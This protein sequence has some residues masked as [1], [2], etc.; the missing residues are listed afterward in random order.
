M[1]VGDT[2]TAAGTRITATGAAPVLALCRKLVERGFDPAT[3]LEAY[4]GRHV[5][6]RVSSLAAGAGLDVTTNRTGRPV[7]V[8][9]AKASGS[10]SGWPN[11]HVLMVD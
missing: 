7:F 8:H 5:C 2:A 11:R 3:P 9:R 1:L 10:L 4:R 6:L